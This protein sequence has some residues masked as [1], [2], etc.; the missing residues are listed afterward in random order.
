VK[1]VI[2]AVNKMDL[3]DYSE[4]VYKIK[5]DFEALNAKSTFKEQNVSYI[6]LSA[7]TGD[8]VVDKTDAMPW[9]KGQTILEHLEALEPAD[10]YERGQAFSGA[11]CDSTKT[12]EYHDFRGY[13]GKLYGNNI[14]RV[15][16][17]LLNRVQSE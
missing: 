1:E 15:L 5:A 16:L 4:E 10:V 7:L 9:Y 3:V 14:R 13:A 8:N 6:P 11:N 2:V 12:E 17:Y